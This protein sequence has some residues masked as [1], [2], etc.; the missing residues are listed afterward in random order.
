[1]PSGGHAT[2]AMRQRRYVARQREQGEVFL[3][4]SHVPTQTLEQ[5]RC[6]AQYRE[7]AVSEMISLIL[8]T[9]YEV[10]QD[11]DD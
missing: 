2:A 6:D 1:M 3:P 10:Q 9:Y 11:E 8:R 5:L 4:R 7:I